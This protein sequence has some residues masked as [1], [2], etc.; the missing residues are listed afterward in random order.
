MAEQMGL[1]PNAARMEQLYPYVQNILKGI[2]PLDEL[3]LTDVEPDMLFTPEEEST[4]G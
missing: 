2:A 4:T 3:D 1:D